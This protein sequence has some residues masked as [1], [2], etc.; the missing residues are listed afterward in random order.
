MTAEEYPDPLK[1]LNRV[2][3][4]LVGWFVVRQFRT[5]IPRFAKWV[6]NS[7]PHA[8]AC[9][10]C[11]Q[12]FALYIW[13][14]VLPGVV[15][16]IAGLSGIAAVCYILAGICALWAFACVISAI[17]PQREYKRARMKNGS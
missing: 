3:R 14:F 13:A 11:G 9:C 8:T 1:Y 4:L 6:H 16:G 10:A 17:K 15:F 2:E 7:G 5:N 12:V